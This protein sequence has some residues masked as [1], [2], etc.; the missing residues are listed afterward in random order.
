M[1]KFVLAYHGGGMA[2][3][4]EEQAEAMAAW[5]AWFEGLGPALK[6]PGNPS[7]ATKTI[8]ADGS[9]RDGGGSN[10]VTGFSIL[11]A[12][13]LD[14]VV[15]LAKSNPIIDSGGSIEVIEAIEM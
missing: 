3:T 7:G 15:T 6:D 13:S 10:P 8:G 12:R 9:V 1:A 11:E 4:D 14:E 5:G 2:E